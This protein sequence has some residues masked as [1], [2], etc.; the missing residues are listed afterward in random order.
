MLANSALL[1]TGGVYPARGRTQRWAGAGSSHRLQA[2]ALT[3][4][5]GSERES[6]PWHRDLLTRDFA[7]CFV[8]LNE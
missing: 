4:R 5:H 8:F 6:Y 3:E 1:P 7:Q 2:R